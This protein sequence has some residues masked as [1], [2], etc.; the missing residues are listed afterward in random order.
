M[1]NLTNLRHTL[2][3]FPELSGQENQTSRLLHGLLKNLN[4]DQLFTFIGSTSLIAV[5][6]SF[7]EGNTVVFRADMDALPIS[8][9]TLLPYKSQ[10]P[11]VSHKCGHDGHSTILYGLADYI[12][13]N[14]PKT[15]KVILLW[16]A[17]EETGKGA[18][19]IIND[20]K[21]FKPTYCFG[22]HNLP[23]Y[24]INTIVVKEGTFAS[25]SEGMI[26]DLKGIQ[27]HASEPEKGNNPA[28]VL[29]QL[30]LDIPKFSTGINEGQ[31]NENYSLIT[32]VHANLGE[33]ALGISPSEARLMMTLRGSSN[34]TIDHLKSRIS[35]LVD[36]I[37][38]S[39][40]IGYN[41]SFSDAFP[42]TVNDHEAVQII[43]DAASQ[44]SLK[45]VTI[46]QA[47]RWSE[48]FAHYASIS[49]AAIFGLG[50]GV[51][52]LPLHNPD[53][54]FPDEMINSGV[55]IFKSIY[56]NLCF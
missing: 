35:L 22:L 34:N 40:N 32:I 56:S 26:I 45:L 23:G 38:S 9:T 10:I 12:S 29:A 50:A 24:E 25:A 6:D 21:P 48:D 7:R 37:A 31:L 41:I 46:D 15:G 36:G 33:P 11:G 53:Y 16:Q 17:A 2:H 47:F 20:I 1:N 44:I 27:S 54:D 18:K 8:E 5:F 28:S 55:D 4:P 43:N 39:H 52:H 42:A 19:E 14:R 30:I 13:N 51:D 49:K 3:K